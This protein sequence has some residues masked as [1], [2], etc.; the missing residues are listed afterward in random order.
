MSPATHGLAGVVI[1]GMAL[2]ACPELSQNIGDQLFLLTAFLA[3]QLPDCDLVTLLL[4]KKETRKKSP[5]YQHRGY[6]HSLIAHLFYATLCPLLIG[7]ITQY[8]FCAFLYFFIQVAVHLL[9]DMIDGSFGIYYLAPVY[10]KPFAC[11]GLVEDVDDALL[12][13]D[14]AHACA[15]RVAFSLKLC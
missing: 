9:L 8:Y 15:L 13:C 2:K 10:N 12:N 5:L 1:G 14:L 11:Y 4:L 6:G 7:C 3:G